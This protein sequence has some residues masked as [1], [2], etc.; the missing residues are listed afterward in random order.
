MDRRSF[1]RRSFGKASEAAVKHMDDKVSA[2]AARWI[3]PPFAI[4]E[5]EFILACTR[6]N[7]CIEA[8]PHDV[9]FPLASRLGASVVNTPAL[10][11]LNRSCHLCDDWPCVTA[12]EPSALK[13]PEAD[14]P[15]AITPPKIAHAE[16]DTDTCLPYSGPECGACVPLCPVS[17]ALYLEMEKPIIDQ[18]ECV[19]CGMCLEACIM[20]PKA[21]KITSLTAA[22]AE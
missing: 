11:L 4:D 20:E 14:K 21:V 6:C 13:L 17:G 15:E 10:D 16:I 9:I 19:G 22:A 5:I 1:F 7:A 18:D 3:R 2:K 8:C 12:C